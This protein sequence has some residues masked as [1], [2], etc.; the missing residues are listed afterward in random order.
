MLSGTELGWATLTLAVWW[1]LWSLADVYLLRYSP[2][3]EGGVLCVCLVLY[4]AAHCW[5]A[6]RT[7]HASRAAQRYA[8]RAAPVPPNELE[9]HGDPPAA[10]NALIE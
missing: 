7:T 4:G 2:W 5:E 10:D 3:S 6:D 9:L 1:A 8:R